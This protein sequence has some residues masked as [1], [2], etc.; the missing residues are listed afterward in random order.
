M[1][2]SSPSYAPG[3]SEHYACA[4]AFDG[5]GGFGRGVGYVMRGHWLPGRVGASQAALQ[6]QAV[7]GD[8]RGCRVEDASGRAVAEL[9]VDTAGLREVLVE[10][11]DVLQLGALPAVDGLVGVAD[12]E[13]VVAFF[14][15]LA[16]QDVLRQVRI[17]VLV[18]QDVREP[19]RSAFADVGHIVQQPDGG[20]EHIVEVEGVAGVQRAL[21]HG[22]EAALELRVLAVAVVARV[23]HRVHRV[24]QNAYLVQQRLGP[25]DA[26]IDALFE[27]AVAYQRDAV[28]A[29][30][31]AV[32]GRDADRLPVLAQDGAAQAMEGR[33]PD[34]AGVRGTEQGVDAFFHLAGRLAGEGQGRRS[35]GGRRRG[36]GP[37]ARRA[38]R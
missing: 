33:D 24:L 19:F 38:Y 26:G 16:Q 10:A 31:D 32:A 8:Q 35:S 18:D 23:G 29:V 30:D 34:G 36:R 15:E 14:G 11:E 25:G 17:L 28:G 3:A 9:E 12:G 20:Q 37:D 21:V 1:R 2:G 22:S 6:P 13:D 27:H 4:G 5:A 7:G